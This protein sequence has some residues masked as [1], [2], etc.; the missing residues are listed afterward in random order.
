MGQRGYRDGSEVKVGS[1]S[2]ES[3]HSE[4]KVR[5]Q[6]KVGVNVLQK[7]HLVFANSRHSISPLPTPALPCPA[8]VI[9]AFDQDDND[10]G[11]D[12]DDGNGNDD[13][14]NAPAC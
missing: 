14:D 12:A 8:G 1:K 11:D 13:D 5:T 4:V 7:C 3:G 2:A 9:I 10:A 6:V